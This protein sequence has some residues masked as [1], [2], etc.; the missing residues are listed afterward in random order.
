MKNE[1]VETISGNRALRSDCRKIRGEFY[2]VGDVTKKDSGDCYKING[3]YYKG[4]TGYIIYDHRLKQ[5]VVKKM[6]VIVEKGVIGLDEKEEPIFGSFSLDMEN[7]EP[8][9]LRWKSC[10]YNVLNAEILEKS[11][12]FQED[13]R[14]GVFVDRQSID[15]IHFIQPAY[16]NQDMKRNLPYD[17]TGRL[18]RVKDQYNKMYTPVLSEAVKKYQHAIGDLSFG[19]EFE[20]TRGLI[21]QRIADPLG[22]MALR[23]GSIQGLEYVTI[24]LQGAKGMQA[25]LDSLKELRKRTTYDDT[26][27]LHFHIGNIPRTEEFFLAFTRIMFLLQDEMF[28]LFPIYKKENYGVKRKHYTK[29]YEYADTV[30]HFDRVITPDKVTS[31]FKEL[32]R[33]LSMGQDY[34]EVGCKLENVSYH[35][36]DPHGTS[37]WNIKSRYYWVNL[38][39]LLFGNKQTV[40]FRLHTPTYDSYKIMNYLVLCSAIVNYTIKNTKSILENPSSY[41]NIRLDLIIS[42]MFHNT[43]GGGV[44][45][46]GLINYFNRRRNYWHNCVKNN[47]IKGDEKKF[48]FDRYFSWE[49]K[50]KD[51]YR[52]TYGSGIVDTLEQL[53]REE[54]VQLHRFVPRN[55]LVIGNNRRRRNPEREVP[56]N[57]ERARRAVEMEIARLAADQQAVDIAGLDG[58]VFVGNA[59]PEL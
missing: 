23:D 10:Q 45:V 17:S 21:P 24:P 40:E 36:S 31:N 35:P 53:V 44:L 49:G 33:F 5:Y 59:E 11:F 50:M 51:S 41:A 20:T 37:K 28:D 15:A 58:P 39:P 27:A 43:A 7:P 54:P 19:V 56:N 16:I 55:D 38:I 25:L 30:Y 42:R 57:Q 22:L 18:G 52:H 12:R 6:N 13:M 34:E 4:H 47:D 14:S 8:P 2:K 29:P 48:H 3:R 1:I 26:C 46:D 9:L 32:Y